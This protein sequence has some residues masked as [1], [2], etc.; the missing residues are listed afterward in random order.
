MHIPRPSTTNEQEKPGVGF[1]FVAFGVVDSSSKA[2]ASLRARTFD[3]RKVCL[4]GGSSSVKAVWCYCWSL[5]G[6][7]CRCT[8]VSTFGCRPANI[9]EKLWD[10]VLCEDVASCGQLVEVSAQGIGATPF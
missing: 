3:G 7:T 10:E 5:C 4:G 6:R 1:V 2:A 8:E 9:L